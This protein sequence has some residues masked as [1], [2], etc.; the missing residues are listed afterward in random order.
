MT[1]GELVVGSPVGDGQA[2]QLR[3]GPPRSDALGR[4]SDEPIFQQSSGGFPRTDTTT[5]APDAELQ[6]STAA[7]AVRVRPRRRAESLP[8]RPASAPSGTPPRAASAGV[9]RMADGDVCLMNGQAPIGLRPRSSSRRQLDSTSA[10][11]RSARPRPS[12]PAM[13]AK[14]APRLGGPQ[15]RETPGS[16][17]RHTALAQPLRRGRD[18]PE[19]RM[20]R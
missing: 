12:D 1:P 13:P 5:R 3:R 4:P 19:R 20:T 11:R 18:P 6:V 10:D 7:P 2:A 17:S 16:C 14:A 15:L 9:R 8:A